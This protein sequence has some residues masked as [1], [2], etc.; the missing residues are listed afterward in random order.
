MADGEPT[1]KPTEARPV[2]VATVAVAMADTSIAAPPVAV[3]PVAG[4]V[5]EP[6][7]VDVAPAMDGVKPAIAAN[8]TSSVPPVAGGDQDDIVDEFADLAN[9]QWRAKQNKKKN[10]NGKGKGKGK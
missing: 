9:V 4:P 1:G 8:L 7:G 3:A 2:A 10:G 5:S 6:P